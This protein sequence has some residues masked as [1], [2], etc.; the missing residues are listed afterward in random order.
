MPECRKELSHKAPLCPLPVIS[1][2][3]LGVAFDLVGP[4]PKAKSGNRN[5]LTCMCLEAKFLEAIPL[6]RVDGLTVAESMV[7]IFSQIGILAEIST[8]QGSLFMGK[9]TQELCRMQ[10]TN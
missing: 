7:E 10:N 2:I 4:L 1:H 8:D 6:R 3:Y 5:I 9:M